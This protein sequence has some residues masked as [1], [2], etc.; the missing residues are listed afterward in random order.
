MFFPAT[1]VFY[2]P[3]NKWLLC[4]V[5][6]ELIDAIYVITVKLY[7]YL[8]FDIYLEIQHLTKVWL[9][10]NT[11]VFFVWFEYFNALSF[12]QMFFHFIKYLLILSFLWLDLNHRSTICSTSLTLILYRYYLIL[13]V[14]VPCSILFP[15]SLKCF[16]VTWTNL[17]WTFVLEWNHMC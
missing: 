2:D 15:W 7:Y 12:P 5:C 11:S 14:F 6:A 13:I 9:W 4:I 3:W 1:T 17:G 16:N 8:E 10:L